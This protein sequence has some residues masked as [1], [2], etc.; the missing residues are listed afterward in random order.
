MT[1]HADDREQRQG[2][3]PADDTADDTASEG[4]V[5]ETA[6][7]TTQAGGDGTPGTD[8]GVPPAADAGTEPGAAPKAYGEGRHS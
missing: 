4:Q 8:D 6:Q 2:D 7:M 1:H 5:S 3:Q